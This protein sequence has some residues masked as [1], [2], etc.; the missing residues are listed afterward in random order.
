VAFWE[1][2]N[3]NPASD[4]VQQPVPQKLVFADDKSVRMYSQSKLRDKPSIS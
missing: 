3:L 4:V 2:R 1:I